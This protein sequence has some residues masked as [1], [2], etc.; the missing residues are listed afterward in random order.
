MTKIV[1]AYSGDLATSLAI[2]WLAEHFSAEVATLT[3]DLGGGGGG[4]HS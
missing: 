1:L 2:A 3:L 4:R